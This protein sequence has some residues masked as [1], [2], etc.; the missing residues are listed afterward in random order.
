M[1]YSSSTVMN[2]SPSLC[3]EGEMT[4]LLNSTCRLHILCHTCL[5]CNKSEHYKCLMIGEA[6]RQTVTR[7]IK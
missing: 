3:A 2:C 6:A 4:I 5:K 7:T 1:L